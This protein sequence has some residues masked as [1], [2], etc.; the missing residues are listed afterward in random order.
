M[1]Y[2]ETVQQAVEDYDRM[3]QANFRQQAFLKSLTPLTRDHLERNTVRIYAR[4]GKVTLVAPKNPA[5]IRALA[6]AIRLMG[7]EFQ[8]FSGSEHENWRH[9]KRPADNARL[10]VHV[11]AGV[12]GSACNRIQV[13]TK[14]VETPI[15]EWVCAE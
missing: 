3:Q 4:E 12:K 11:R 8:V 9:Y 7:F 14:T 6:W 13:G 2:Y 1:S 15:Y 10:V 5:N